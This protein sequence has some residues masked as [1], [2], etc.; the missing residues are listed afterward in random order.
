MVTAT[1]SNFSGN[2][3]YLLITVSGEPVVT[4]TAPQITSTTSGQATV[5]PADPSVLGAGAHSGTI[6]VRACS[7]PQCTSGEL[8]GSPAT[9]AVDYLV[10][11]VTAPTQALSYTIGNV[12]APGDDTRQVQ[13]TGYPAADWSVTA[14]QPWLTV[15][16]TPGATATAATL[17][18]TLNPARLDALNNGQYN[19]T[20]TLTPAQGDPLTI[21]VSLKVSRTEV[22]Y[23][24]PYV[25][26]PGSTGQ[27]IIRGDNFSQVTVTG[28]HFGDTPAS[29]FTVVSD[30]EVRATHPG[31]TAGSNPVT[32]DNAGNL[33]RSLASLQAVLPPAFGTAVI[34]YPDFGSGWALHGLLYDTERAALIVAVQIDNGS[35]DSYILRYPYTSAGWGAPT[36]V[37]V[38]KLETIAMSVDGQRLLASGDGLFINQY[39]PVTLAPIN[40]ASQA[41]SI[42]YIPTLGI[43]DDNYV[44]GATAVVGGD[45][46]SQ[47]VKYSIHDGAYVPNFNGNMQVVDRGGTVASLDGSTVLMGSTQPISPTWNEYHAGDGS[48]TTPTSLMSAYTMAADRTGARF[49]VQGQN[50]VDV[51]MTLLGSLPSTMRAVVLSEDGTRLYALDQSN[52]I[53][54]YALVDLVVGVL[55]VDVAQVPLVEDP[56]ALPQIALTR[57]ERTMFVAGY[58]RVV[59]VPLGPGL[60]G[61]ATPA[62]K[63]R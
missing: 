5:V 51:N 39:D 32:L 45:G 34:Q 12:V 17:T 18:A 16:R 56:G 3:L 41:S 61:T 7:Q 44:V 27:V 21:P 43:T 58:A 25:E 36:Q 63:P 4:V 55:P 49:V 37:V 10:Y 33:G 48:I 60:V 53:H 31:L 54:G 19:S 62:A 11:G 8:S 42:L 57:D 1:V 35:G 38:P 26:L 28:V 14:D 2:N 29:A 15:T 59:V 50:I 23:V 20:I 6:T 52:L 22:H 47:L 46:P 30:T 24:S 13:T 40:A 9:I